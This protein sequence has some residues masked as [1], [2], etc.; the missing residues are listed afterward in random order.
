MCRLSHHEASYICTQSAAAAAAA[1][2]LCVTMLLL[3]QEQRRCCVLLLFVIVYGMAIFSAGSYILLCQRFI[4]LHS[5]AI[6]LCVSFVNTVAFAASI[7]NIHGSYGYARSQGERQS[8]GAKPP[9]YYFIK[10]R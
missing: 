3:L 5:N 2:S 10:I 4:F 8:A 6:Y 9:L 1:A 7:Y